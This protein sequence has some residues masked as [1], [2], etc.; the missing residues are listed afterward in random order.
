[1]RSQLHKLIFHPAFFLAI[2]LVSSLLTF[3]TGGLGYFAG[4]FIALIGFWASG[5]KWSKFGISRPKWIKTLLMALCFAIGIFIFVDG[6]FQPLLERFIDPV[7]LSALDHI[8]GNFVNYLFFILI[9]WVVAGFGE[10]FLYRGFFMKQ[11]AE[12]LGNRN[13]SWFLAGLIISTL[14]GIAHLYQGLSG[15]ISTGLIGFILAMIFMAN[16]KNL[17]L[18]MLIHGF[19]DMIGITMIFLNA[20]KSFAQWV[21]NILY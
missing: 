6:L 7:D 8:R 4:I 20:D 15:V 9:M 19:Y 2:L 17:I 16:R 3:Y 5:F 11:L 12:I 18:L 21:Q 14:F 13:I 10:E 1:M